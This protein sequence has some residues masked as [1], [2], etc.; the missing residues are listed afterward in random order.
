MVEKYEEAVD[1]I[2]RVGNKR[3]EEGNGEESI[4]ER[5]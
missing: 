3:K 2:R 5:R 4:D 1:K